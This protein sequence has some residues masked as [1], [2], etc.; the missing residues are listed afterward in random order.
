[1]KLHEKD[2]QVKP[3]MDTDFTPMVR[4]KVKPTSTQPHKNTNKGE[5]RL[6]YDFFNF[7]L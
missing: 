2:N 1:M 5:I 6:K 3:W 7:E 4:V